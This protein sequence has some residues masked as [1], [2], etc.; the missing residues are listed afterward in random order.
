MKSHQWQNA[1]SRRFVVLF[2]LA[3]S[4]F[5][6]ISAFAAPD[7][8]A[9]FKS[10]CGSCHYTNDQVL[11]G[12]GLQGVLGRVPSPEWA[13]AWVHDNNKLRASG[14]A[15]AASIF[16]KFGGKTMTVFGTDLTD[17]EID[18]I[19]AYA[20]KGGDPKPTGQN[21]ATATTTAAT[22]NSGDNLFIIVIILVV[23]IGIIAIL[24]YT[25]INLRNAL[26]EKEGRAEEPALPFLEASKDWMNNNKRKVALMG[27]LL[28]CCLIVKG[29]Y[30]LK[31]IGVYAE[32]VHPDEW[33]GYH[34]SQPINF[35]HKIHAGDVANGG[36]GIQCQY[37]H[38]GVD[39]SK[40]AGIPPVMVCMNCHKVISQNQAGTDESKTE[41]AKIYYATGWDPVTKTF[42]LPQ[43]PVQWN[44]VH[45]LPD[46]VFFSHQQHV[47]VGKQQCETCHGDVK[48][49]TTVEQQRPLTMGWC[50]NCHRT[51]PV[52]MD[53]NGYYTALHEKM[54]EK[55]KDQTIT[56]SMVGGIECSRCHY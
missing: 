32:E 40:T 24:R 33:V 54:K 28:F 36:N 14:D 55:Y 5:F 19:L 10:K 29:W 34:P 46:H 3:I 51:T 26:A 53:G 31:G 18:A 37:C 56:V 16:A 20:D 47:V 9:L 2:T 7:G 50:I 6:S 17:E 12:P 49:M 23:L 45:V 42:S 38:S 41:I 52:A 15:Y 8:K 21:L 1:Q 44:K 27:F 13:R 48:S 11:T 43:H 4:L 39:H 30:A 22:D 35:S 25:K